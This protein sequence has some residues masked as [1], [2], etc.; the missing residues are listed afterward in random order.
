MEPKCIIFDEPTSMLDPKGK[1]EVLKL[2]EDLNKNGIT[3]I[4]I[5][6]DME[7]VLLSKRVVAL[8]D[9]DIRF[10]G[11]PEE[12]FS[13]FGLLERLSLA[14]TKTGELVHMLYNEGISIPKNL[15]KREELIDFLCR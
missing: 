10:D 15:M 2:I 8:L 4:L 13:N 6:Q 3:I 9:G 5:T 14:L 12:L 11:P 1:R 7:E